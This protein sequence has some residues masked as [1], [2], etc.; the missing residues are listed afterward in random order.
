MA[1]YVCD[2]EI[3]KQLNHTPIADFED[4]NMRSFLSG[5]FGANHNLY[6]S[7]VAAKSY[8]SY[9]IFEDLSCI[10]FNPIIADWIFRNDTV[11]PAFLRQYEFYPRKTTPNQWSMEEG[12]TSKDT[13]NYPLKSLN[14]GI[15]NGL[16]IVLKNKKINLQTIDTLCQKDPQTVNIAL[17]H[18]A[19]VVSKHD[20]ITVPFNKS[21]TFLVK[22]KV[23]KTSDSLR[24]YA[25]EV[26]EI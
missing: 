15:Q 4:Y 16:K 12:Y 14:K 25:P 19:E 3:S 20:F 11:D 9:K 5:K 10:T 18:P 8:Y 2:K 26:Y 17:H 21:V 1:S 6:W 23:T 7:N 22:P 13:R 24:A